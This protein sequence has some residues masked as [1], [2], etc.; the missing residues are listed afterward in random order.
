MDSTATEIIKQAPAA[1]GAVNYVI[2]FALMVIGFVA[3]KWNS[4]FGKKK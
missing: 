1:V 2:G 4:I 3:G